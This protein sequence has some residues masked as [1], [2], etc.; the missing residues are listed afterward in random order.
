MYHIISGYT[1]KVDGTERCITEPFE[2]FSTCF[3]APFL[4]RPPQVYGNLFKKKISENT[5]L[6]GMSRNLMS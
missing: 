2:T 3:G 6:F 5:E 1:A 4:P